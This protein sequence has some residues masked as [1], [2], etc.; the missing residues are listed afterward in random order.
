[1]TSERFQQGLAVRKAVLG[2]AH[3]ERSL[4]NVTDFDRPMQELTTEFCWGTVWTRPGLTRK[5]RSLINLAMLSALNRPE[6]LALHIRGAVANGCTPEEIC[7]VFLQV[8]VYCGIPAG[9]ESFKVGKR[10]LA[11]L[12]NEGR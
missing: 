10:V 1:M 12:Q 5:E 2:E 7:E 9:M 6:E 4:Q 8:A 3:V 11:E